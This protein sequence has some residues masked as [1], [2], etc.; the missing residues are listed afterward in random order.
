MSIVYENRRSGLLLRNSDDKL[1]P[2]A[3][4][5]EVKSVRNGFVTYLF[6]QRARM[7]VV[8]V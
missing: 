4:T 2:I 1:K 7:G 8:P 5:V 3:K 6:M